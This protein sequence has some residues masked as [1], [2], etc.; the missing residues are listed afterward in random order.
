MLRPGQTVAPRS[1]P[2]AALIEAMLPDG[3]KAEPRPN[4]KDGHRDCR[5][6]PMHGPGQSYSDVILRG[7]HALSLPTR[8]FF[9]L[10]EQ[11]GPIVFKW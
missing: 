1:P 9:A 3:Y 8:S 2:H 4:G 7:A 6:K 5:L 10:R 11:H